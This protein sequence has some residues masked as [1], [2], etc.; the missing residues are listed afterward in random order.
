MIDAIK[1]RI[2]QGMPVFVF[3][4]IGPPECVIVAG[5]KDN[6]N[7]SAGYSFFLRLEFK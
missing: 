7:I 2:N 4:I 5:Y 1:A 3:R 6:G